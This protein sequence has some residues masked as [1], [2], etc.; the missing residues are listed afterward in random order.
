MKLIK[1]ANHSLERK[2]SRAGFW[3]SLPLIIGVVIF[4]VPAVFNVIR[5]SLNDIGVLAGGNGYSL[6]FAGL[7]YYKESLFEDAKFTRM[8]LETLSTILV[9]TPVILIFSLFAASLLSQEFKGRAFARIVFFI[10][11]IVSTGIV[12]FI[13]NNWVSAMTVS[14]VGNV[15]KEDSVFG[16]EALLTQIEIGE[17][18]IQ[19]LISAANEVNQIIRS[20]GMQIYIFLAAFNEIP[21]A[22][23]EAAKVEGCSA[24]ECF[25]KITIPSVVP[26]IIICA[27][28]TLIDLYTATD[29]AI[30]EYI[31]NFAFVNKEQSLAAAMNVLYLLLVELVILAFFSIVKISGR[32]EGARNA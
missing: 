2:K 14:E 9:K 13:D 15:L 3:F 31:R 7:K 5:L 19:V 18:F 1:K 21:P 28:Y 32:K 30:Y 4:F 25:W 16:V 11:V 17:K 26:Q 23:Y 6:S 22:L 29:T 10:P 12:S 24:W 20:S 27:V 8:L